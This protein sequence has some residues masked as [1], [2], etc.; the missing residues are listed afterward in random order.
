MNALSFVKF[1]NKK[2]HTRQLF[3]PDPRKLFHEKALMEKSI[4]L[5]LSHVIKYCLVC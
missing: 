4:H 3:V 5:N 1:Y 2:P